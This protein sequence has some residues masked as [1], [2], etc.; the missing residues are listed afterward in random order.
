[1]VVS[2]AKQ[3]VTLTDPINHYHSHSPSSPLYKFLLFLGSQPNQFHAVQFPRLRSNSGIQSQFPCKIKHSDPPNPKHRADQ[4]RAEQS[5]VLS[6]FFPVRKATQQF[7]YHPKPLFRPQQPSL[8]QILLRSL[9]LDRLVVRCSSRFH[10][11]NHQTPTTRYL[12]IRFPPLLVLHLRHP[13]SFR[14]HQKPYQKQRAG[15]QFGL[16]F[17]CWRARRGACC[18]FEG[19]SVAVF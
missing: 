11:R 12:P 1:M 15:I 5:N 7:Q 14:R 18:V 13:L 3:T 6:S 10:S 2:L 17:G 19:S 9:R 4:S 16:G 8:L